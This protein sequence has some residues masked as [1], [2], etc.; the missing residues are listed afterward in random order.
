MSEDTLRIVP[1]GGLGEI[2]MNC[3]VLEQGDDL[4]VVDCGVS[5]PH[6]DL[7]T[8]IVHPR[9]DYVLE[10]RDRLRGV[11][12]THGHEDHIGALP[13]LLDQVATP[14]WAPAHAM[15]LIRRRLSEWQFDLAALPLFVTE[16]GVPFSVGSFRIET[17]RV[18]HS[19]ADATALAIDTVAGKVVHTG[20]FKL[21]EHPPDGEKTDEARFRSLGDEGV[22]LLLSDSTNVDS[23]GASA[24]E[25][26]VGDELRRVIGEAPERVVVG[27][28]AS[29]V[30][31]LI[32]L[33]E[34]AQEHRRKVVLL[35]RSVM[36][37]VEVARALGLLTWPSNLV[38]APELAQGMP[39]REVLVLASGTQAERPAAL[40]R[41]ATGEHPRFRLEAGDLVLFSSRIIPG[42]DRAVFDLYA[43]FLRRGI[44][45][46]SRATFP[47]L[48]ASGHAHR[49]EQLRMIEWVRPRSF[50]PVHGTLHH[51]RRHASLAELAGVGDVLVAENGEVVTL[52]KEAALARVDQ[53]TSGKVHT[54]E[55]T[56]VPDEVLRE[57]AR[58]AR[59]GVLTVALALTPRGKLAGR[60]S[61]TATGVLGPLDGDVLRRVERGAEH[62]ALDAIDRGSSPSEIEDQIR[63]VARRLVFSHTSQKPFVIVSLL[64]TDGAG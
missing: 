39:R 35:G 14:V 59:S 30:Q 15:A 7:G 46:E 3:L 26:L 41:L 63:L 29:N 48:H 5:F 57:R 58:I 56:E 51:L 18:T 9:F 37:H 50:L 32:Q 23:P 34:I 52:G 36:Q 47:R 6:E 10:R 4:I 20:D 60:P 27:L 16:T 64:R 40:H 24:S 31:R 43:S 19:I 28:F 49:D 11:V 33:G 55:R 1:L 54:F 22:R 13:Y 17:L 38:V 8:D 25:E 44:E 12:I 2:G 21:D 42:N 62:A 45:V 61:V 53:I